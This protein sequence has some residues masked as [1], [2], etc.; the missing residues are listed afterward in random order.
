[1]RQ[2]T[3]KTGWRAQ[4]GPSTP[5]ACPALPEGSVPNR[6]QNHLIELLPK[7]D[8][9]RLLAQCEWVQLTSGEVLCEADTT[10]R[11]AY[12]PVGSFISLLTRIQHHPSLE[13]G[14]AG[15]EGCFGSTLTLGVHTAALQA[16]VQGSGTAWRISAS[17]LREQLAASP[18]LQ[19][20]LMR[21]LYVVMEQMVSAS[22]CLRFH[23]IGPRLARWLLMSQD[24]AQAAHFHITHEF[25]AT[26]L[27][28]RRVGVTMAAGSKPIFV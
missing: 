14:M 6:L 21:Y 15:H 24:R 26:M 16:M 20:L 12:F 9:R 7:A 10:M 8:Q 27:G 28:V 11:H 1:M 2:Q 13:V 23:L 3:V 25:L 18:A 22:A 5:K 19:R 17:G 4:T